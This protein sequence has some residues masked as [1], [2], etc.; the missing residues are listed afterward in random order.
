MS[1][2]AVPILGFGDDGPIPS[3]VRWKDGTRLAYAGILG[4]V[5]DPEAQQAHQAERAR[6]E[7]LRSQGVAVLSDYQ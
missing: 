4:G 6:K 7:E 5:F 3:H 1:N 2:F